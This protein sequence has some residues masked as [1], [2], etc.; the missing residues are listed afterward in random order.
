LRTLFSMI[1]IESF[2][3]SSST[4]YDLRTAY[5]QPFLFWLA[6]ESHILPTMNLLAAG[7]QQK[8]WDITIT[9]HWGWSY[10]SM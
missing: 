3:I 9:Q 6:M 10:S 7:L 4:I 2:A 1:I 8:M 5:N